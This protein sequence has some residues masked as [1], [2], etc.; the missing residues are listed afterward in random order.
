M[1][2]IEQEGDLLLVEARPGGK[3]MTPWSLATGQDTVTF[4][5]CHGGTQQPG[6]GGTRPPAPGRLGH[7]RIKL[8]F[9]FH[10]TFYGRGRSVVILPSLLE[11]KL[12]LLVGYS[13]ASSGLPWP[14]NF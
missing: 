14:K 4:Q 10:W 11:Q 3:M 13:K 8:T 7:V 9:F 2:T 5:P 12:G 6:H 1:L